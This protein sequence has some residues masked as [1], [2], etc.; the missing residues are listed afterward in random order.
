MTRDHRDHRDHRDERGM[1]L[2]ELMIST[3]LGLTLALI[4]IS[5]LMA[6]R[7]SYALQ[8][9]DARMQDTGRVALELI[10]RAIRH[11]G[12]EN[13]ARDGAALANVEARSPD[14]LGLDASSLKAS[15]D[16]LPDQAVNGSDVLLLRYAGSGAGS[17]GDGS[18][19]NCAGFGVGE[20]LDPDLDRGW[21]IFYV[22]PEAV[23]GEPE[24]RCRYL[25]TSASGKQSWKSDAIVAGVE[26]FQ[27]LYGLDSDGDGRA[28]RFLNANAIRALDDA[29][30]FGQPDA[31]SASVD[32]KRRTHWK[33]VVAIR[34]ALLIRG[35]A[36]Q[37][38]GAGANEFDLFG[39][40][41]SALYR[42]TDPGVHFS[43]VTDAV[44]RIRKLYTG[45]FQLRNAP[46]IGAGSPA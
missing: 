25:G 16:L 43:G 17:S 1:G 6:G 31:A 29:Q 39:P 21:S 10:G 44:R 40:A 19:V 26:D 4:A 37:G 11:A 9:D 28:D 30:G 24:L 23:S 27:V 14:V 20:A 5:L 36:P 12:W 2:V 32:S 7:A 42:E 18:T 35:D 34:I 3:A 38:E 22:A 41:Y 46:I 15:V 45:T 33:K 13:W 8:D